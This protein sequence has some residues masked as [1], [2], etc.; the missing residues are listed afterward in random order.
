[1]KLYYAKTA[2]LKGSDQIRYFND[3]YYFVKALLEEY[4][5]VGKGMV[6]LEVIDP[7]PFSDEE[8]DA[9]R[10][11]LRRFTI[12]EEEGFFFGLV[13][14]TQFGVDKVIDFFS[15]Q[16][17]NF[18]E[19]D[20]SYLID[21]AITR[22]KK[23][24]GILSSLSVMGDDVSGYMAQMMRMQ[25]QQPKPAWSIVRHMEQMYE[26]SS[27]EP[28][29]DE[30]TDVD[31]LMVI[32]PKELSDKTLFAIDQFVLKGGRTIVFVDPYCYLD[33]PDP[34]QMQMGQVTNPSSE[35]D[36]LLGAWGLEL[37]KN[38]FAGDRKLSVTARP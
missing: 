23:R 28:E 37:P 38:T 31:I 14:Q 22:E 16:R 35:F 2:A 6:E 34:R 4:A 32:H 30:I 7:R 26:V 21:T 29:V 15:P 3:Y 13:V 8:A 10:N 12:T 1:M 19:Y 36:K 20:I 18:V 17:Q 25:G 9:I 24:V 27:V 33:Q 11:G 5:A